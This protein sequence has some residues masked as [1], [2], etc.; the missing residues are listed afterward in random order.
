M[1][2][3]AY[4]KCTDAV[5]DIIRSLEVTGT[6]FGLA[7]D[8]LDRLKIH[9]RKAVLRRASRNLHQRRRVNSVPQNIRKEI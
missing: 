3:V 9:C 5:T 4:E 6:M 2:V 1:N 7:G 8:E